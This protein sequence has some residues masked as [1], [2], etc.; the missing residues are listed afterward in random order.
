MDPVQAP[1]A[2]ADLERA[3]AA[4]VDLGEVHT[5]GGPA[6]VVD[7]RGVQAALAEASRREAAVL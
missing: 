3:A 5:A 2:A 1:A 6:R 4:V 7:P